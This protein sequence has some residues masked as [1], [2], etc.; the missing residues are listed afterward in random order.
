M[1][2][3]LV[4]AG[5]VFGCGD[6]PSSNVD[7]E[8]DPTSPT[9]PPNLCVDEGFGREVAFDT[10]GPF[11]VLRHDLAEDFTVPLDDGT[12]WSLSAAW[13]GCESYVFVPDGIPATADGA[14]SIWDA[15]L[16]QLVADSPDNVHYFFVSTADDN[17]SANARLDALAAQRT[18]VLDGLRKPNAE[19]WAG[20][21]HIV[22]KRADN[23]NSWVGDLLGDPVGREG[24]AIDRAQRIRGI[25]SVA[26]VDRYN[27]A[28]SWWNNNLAM[29]ANEVEMYNAEA[30]RQDRLDAVTP[31]LVPMF[32][33]EVISG[34][35]EADLTL[36]TADEMSDF[37]T[38]EIDVD[39]RCPDPTLGEAGNC[40]AWDYLAHLSVAAD[41][42]TWIELSRF[43]T[44]YHREARWVVDATPMMAHLLDGG[45]RR[46][47]W[48]WA[49]EWNVQPTETRLTLRF[50][51]QGRGIYP[52]SVV[53]VATG[54][55]FGSLYNDGRV[56]VD[57]DIPADVAKVELVTIVTG[58]GAGTSSCAE[59]CNHQHE[60][61][62]GSTTT[63]IEFPEAGTNTGCED[64]GIPNQ[65]T[66][67]QWGTWWFG[68]GG[69]CPGQPVLPHVLDVTADVTPGE[70][71]TVSYRG[72]FGGN[73]PLDGSGDILLNSWIVTYRP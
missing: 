48:E 58:H 31:V 9:V 52:A 22:A 55:P 37:D 56:P 66:P 3:T 54:G 11:G 13:T 57:V 59:F 19:R 16:A 49:P 43:I 65:M 42:G 63:L 24:F 50:S 17:P 15:D 44:T 23:L 46:F 20:R 6:E 5:L 1:V 35:A 7:P 2:R 72:L 38:F 51:N 26:D 45:T 67:N 41:D 10:V 73:T 14:G 21:L 27:G 36:P 30:E 70:T 60:F 25:G 47:R 71:V 64:A 29:V 53:N 18:E 69:W 28:A 12:D 32:D 40:G 39:M 33:G 4:V 68:R 62:V 34:F 61:T 8:P